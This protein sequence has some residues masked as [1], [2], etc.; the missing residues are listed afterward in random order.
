G[1]VGA[2]RAIM[3]AVLDHLRAMGARTVALEAPAFVASPS[4]DAQLV[5]AMCQG[6]DALGRLAA[7]EEAGAVV[8]NSALAIRN[9]YRDLL[10]LGLSKARVPAPAGAV[11]RTA[12]PLD[13]T[14]LQALDLSRPVYVKRGDLHALAEEDVSRVTGATRLE[15]TLIRFAQRGIRQAYIQQ[16]VE[17]TVVKFYGVGNGE[18][19]FSTIEDDGFRLAES[20]CRQLVVAAGRGAQALGL[21]VW[22]GDAVVATSGFSVIDFNDWP[23]F[24]RVRLEAAAAIARRGLERMRRH[25]L[26][27][28]LAG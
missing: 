5:L 21:E 18:Q 25:S 6:G 16:E 17:G 20:V 15:A 14:A 8:I 3:D 19:Y 2:D 26:N 11:V 4:P 24:E 28:D 22:G 23:S 7:V 13:F 9:C 1:K 27:R 10:G 12:A